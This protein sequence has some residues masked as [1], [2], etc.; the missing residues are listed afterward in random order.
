M[1]VFKLALKRIPLIFLSFNCYAQSSTFHST[2]I[3]WATNLTWEQVKRKAMQD[4]IFI[5]VDCFATWCAPCKWMDKNV[6]PNDTVA[7]F[8]NEKF[9]CVRVQLDSNKNDNAETQ[10]WYKTAAWLNKEYSIKAMPTFLFFSPTGTIVHSGI[11]SQSVTQFISLAKDALDSSKQFYTLL[12]NYYAGKIRYD[13]MPG[14]ATTAK[15]LGLDQEAYNIAGGYMHGYIDQLDDNSFCKKENQTF[16]QHFRKI[17]TS[18]DRVF[19]ICLNT[20][21]KIDAVTYPGYSQNLADYVIWKE[22]VQPAMENDNKENK[23]PDWNKIA[24]VVK[25]KYGSNYA[26]RIVLSVKPGFYKYKKDWNNYTKYLI[27]QVEDFDMRKASGLAGANYLNEKAWE[28]FLHSDKMNQLERVVS[29]CDFALK[30]TGLKDSIAIAGILD[31]KAN[32][33]YKLGRTKEALHLEEKAT[34]MD[35]NNKDIEQAFLKMKESKST[36]KDQ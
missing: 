25:T 10:S 17:V 32:L 33:I 1:N 34:L 9:I 31:T 30:L 20:P 2:D 27:Q 11:G 14:L 23:M 13:Q 26:N 5:F 28:I 6:Y 36:W 35:P 19:L 29:W 7:G 22:D 24:S 16:I 4:N 3:K 15:Q 21:E 12:N 18:K 8:M